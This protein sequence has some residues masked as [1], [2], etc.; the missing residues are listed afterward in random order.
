MKTKAPLIVKKLRFWVRTENVVA[1]ISIII[2]IISLFAA[3]LTPELRKALSLTNERYV[4]SSPSN[5]DA[6]RRQVLE[7][8]I[9]ETLS[10]YA[11]STAFDEAELSKYWIPADKGGKESERIKHSVENLSKRGMRYGKES[12]AESFEILS[13]RI[14]SPG[15][16]AEVETLERWFLPLYYENGDRVLDRN[17]YIGPYRVVYLLRKINGIWLIEDSSISRANSSTTSN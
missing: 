9:Y 4:I 15:D 17:S 1:I 14:Y 11:N 10:L 12:K 7:S 2:A 13:V 8:Q 16:Y 3:F 6:I 5:E